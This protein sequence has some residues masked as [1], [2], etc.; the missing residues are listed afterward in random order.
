M[1]KVTLNDVTS[2]YSAATVVNA[3][4]DRVEAALE[5]TLS[6]DGSTP[7]T[8]GA[9]LDM[10]SNRVINVGSPQ[11]G[12]DAARW[13]DVTSALAIS[14]ALPSQTGNADRAIYTDGS[15]LAWRKTPYISRTAAEIA[16][17]VTPSDNSYAVADVKR[18]GA[19]G[20]GSTD[21]TAAIQRAHDALP[22]T[23]GTIYFSGP[24]SLYSMNTNGTYVNIS[25]NNVTLLGDAGTWVVSPASSDP[26]IKTGSSYLN[27]FN[28]TGNDCV[29]SVNMRGALVTWN[30]SSANTDRLSLRDC[31][32]RNM[33]NSAVSI[34]GT[35]GFSLLDVDGCLFDTSRDLTSDAGNYQV[36]S[37]GANAASPAAQL[38]RINR[39][40]FRG[41]RGGVDIHNLRQLEIGG[42]TRFEGC[43]YFAFKL[44]TQDSLDAEMNVTVDESVTFDGAA[45]NSSS[46]NRHLACTGDGR[47]VANS[48]IYSM[49]LTIFHNVKIHGS[50]KNFPNSCIEITDGT[51]TQAMLDFSGARFDTCANAVK[52]MQGMVKFE[53]AELI[54][55]G[56]VGFNGATLRSLSFR[57]NRMR[58]SYL[59]IGKQC[60]ALGDVLLI[61][62]N[63]CDY[64][65]DNNGV[66]RFTDYGVDTG[67]TLILRKNR[68]KLTGGGN[69]VV[70]TLGTSGT[71]GWFDA[72]NQIS[73]AAGTATVTG[74]YRPNTYEQLT[75]GSGALYLYK[76][77]EGDITV[78]NPNASASVT[79][80]IHDAVLDA[81]VGT[82]FHAICT[83]ASNALIFA[84]T[85]GAIDGG[86]T[87]T[88]GAQW[89][90]ATLVKTGANAWAIRS[91]RGTVTVS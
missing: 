65:V 62:H 56:I 83:H 51:R 91:G 15:A 59:T 39:S 24:G 75:T 45:I 7:N 1:P 71:R 81:P 48:A 64:S 28:I 4:N 26:E 70:A 29:V 57:R 54:S 22:S 77:H 32:F 82:V 60:V 52:G 27:G 69:T 47:S 88:L 74:G 61:E 18:Y 19:V 16:G 66:F 44:A 43:N 80:T 68:I 38:V 20:D 17:S 31:I 86:T 55:S 89:S 34:T 46:A 10:N 13:A 50:F 78:V 9:S 2:G 37:R 79:Y 90:A 6:R 87:V 3:N 84:S 76:R 21:D 72:D 63:D 42:G 73:A 85:G 5:N 49:F 12:T 53:G 14:T 36:L 11:S 33:Y 67:A 8:M 58:D 41:V 25:K 40:T 30:C 35:N 23:G